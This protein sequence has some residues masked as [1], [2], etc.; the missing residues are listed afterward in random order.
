MVLN[1]ALNLLIERVSEQASSRA[2]DYDAY[3]VG[4]Y[5]MENS[6][7]D[8]LLLA[9]V[10]GAKNELKAEKIIVSAS[11]SSLFLGKNV[12]INFMQQ[13]QKFIG[14]NRLAHYRTAYNSKRIVFGGGSVF[15]TA[16]D[17]EIKRHMMRLAAT[18][19]SIAVGVSLGPFVD[20]AAKKQCQRFLNECSF[21]GLRDRASLEIAKELAPKANVRLTFDLAPLIT[22]APN[23]NRAYQEQAGV[24]INICPV[25]K[26]ADGT[27][28]E[29]EQ[30]NLLSKMKQVVEGIWHKTQQPIT[31]ISLNG[32]PSLGDQALCTEL[33]A[34]CDKAIPIELLS[35]QSN[36]L[37]AIEMIRGFQ[38]FV[39][40]RLHGCV[41][42]YLANTPVIA[43]NYHNKCQQWCEQIGLAHD[44][45]FEAASFV[46]SQLIKT[47][48]QGLE[49]GFTSPVLAVNEA[50]RLSLSN[51][52]N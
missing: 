32:H 35:Y 31:L 26:R 46:P 33:K 8:A 39:S 14:Q 29:V 51:W 3:L 12:A 15:H 43:L 18:N 7:D 25:P 50:V 10:M 42:G 47:L 24:L 37:K 20:E 36:P 6:G 5:G 48:V 41:F 28:D 49:Y 23:Y 30:V 21:V 11:N 13:K 9:S 44:L 1:Q 16:Q 19:N 52:R 4:Y 22:L 38:A 34:Q 27:V 17:I 45:R 2:C 40:M